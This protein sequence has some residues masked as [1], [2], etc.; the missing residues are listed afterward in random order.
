[1][2]QTQTAV[3]WGVIGLGGIVEQQIAPAIVNSTHSTL[4][5]CMGSTP[6]KSK[7]KVT[8]ADG[9]PELAPIQLK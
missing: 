3:R 8:V 7:Q 9:K 6:E 2:P 5:A 4:V 1:M